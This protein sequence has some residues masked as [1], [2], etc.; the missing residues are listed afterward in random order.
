MDYK[1]KYLKYKKKYLNLVGA[2]N[3]DS[4]KGK[5]TGKGTEKKEESQIDDGIDIRFNP[6]RDLFHNSSFIINLNYFVNL[7]GYNDE[8]S[9]AVD[10]AAST[11]KPSTKKPSTSEPEPHITIYNMKYTVDIIE[12]RIGIFKCLFK[13]NGKTDCFIVNFNYAN[14]KIKIE[15]NFI[16]LNNARCKQQLFI[17]KITKLFDHF[18]KYCNI[19]NPFVTISSRKVE[20]GET[21]AVIESEPTATTPSTQIGQVR[22]HDIINILENTRGDDQIRFEKFIHYETTG[23]DIAKIFYFGK[24]MD[25]YMMIETKAR[26]KNFAN[27]REVVPDRKIKKL[28]FDIYFAET[29][30]DIHI[31][32]SK[33]LAFTEKDNHLRICKYTIHQGS[34]QRIFNTAKHLT[35]FGKDG[36]SQLFLLFEIPQRYTEIDKSRVKI[37]ATDDTETLVFVSAKK[38]DNLTSVDSGSVDSGSVDSGS[39]DSGSVDSGSVVTENFVIEKFAKKMLNLSKSLIDIKSSKKISTQDSQEFTNSFLDVH[40]ELVSKSTT[41]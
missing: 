29:I 13:L 34:S 27:L 23:Y 41:K 12:Y 2:A 31:F 37:V 40:Q 33:G 25:F 35:K 7:F 9:D 8:E 28:E 19:R 10:A 36:N 6:E 32:L 18:I 20:S 30:E 24:Y 22:V 5:G 1:F 3:R 39:V 21:A 16:G 14:G 38:S 17:E 4:R 11:K 26:I 15:I